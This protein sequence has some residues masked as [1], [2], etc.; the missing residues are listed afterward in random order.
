MI[1]GQSCRH[2]WYMNH[3]L[4]ENKRENGIRVSCCLKNELHRI[5]FLNIWTDLILNIWIS[6]ILEFAKSWF[7]WI[8]S[9]MDQHQWSVL[10]QI[11]NSNITWRLIHSHLYIQRPIEP[12][13]SW[14]KPFEHKS[15]GLLLKMDVHQC[16]K[17]NVYFNIQSVLHRPAQSSS[18][19]TFAQN[20]P[21]NSDG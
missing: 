15:L 7:L 12:T 2:Y 13:K 18:P 10:S 19:T 3:D 1:S 9:M 4:I 14:D 17:V 8:Y 16:P 5:H 20:G 21:K 11:L 6:K